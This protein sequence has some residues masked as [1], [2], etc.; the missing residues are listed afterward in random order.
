MGLGVSG[1]LTWRYQPKVFDYLV[2]HSAELDCVC[3]YHPPFFP[4]R[5]SYA[6]STLCPVLGNGVCSY[7][8]AIGTDLACGGV[9]YESTILC[10]VRYWRMTCAGMRYA[11]LTRTLLCNVR[12]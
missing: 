11:A 2:E 3:P 8:L 6:C 7:Q 12:Y 4:M 9:P 1:T 10:G 5:L